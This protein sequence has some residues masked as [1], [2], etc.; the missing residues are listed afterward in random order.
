MTKVGYTLMV[1]CLYSHL[2]VF[3]ILLA[4]PNSLNYGVHR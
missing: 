1:S 2:V 3:R 4:H